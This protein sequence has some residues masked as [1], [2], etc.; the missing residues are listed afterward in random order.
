MTSLIGYLS[1]TFA[2]LTAA[3][4]VVLSIAS[5]KFEMNAVLRVARWMMACVFGL[6]S[7]ASAALIF[8]LLKSDFS[9][10]YIAHYT[11]R[12][13]PV[14]YKVAAF[15]AGQDGSL[16]LWAWMLAGMSVIFLVC[17]RDDRGT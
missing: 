1:L 5:L 11:E 2:L 9:V 10:Q 15:W 8:G 4:A 14:G 16:L 3:M 12:A 13:L 6:L 17:R 7:I